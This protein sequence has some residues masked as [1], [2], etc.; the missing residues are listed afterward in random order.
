L[1][2]RSAWRVWGDDDQLGSI[3]LLS[4]ERVQR[5]L[6]LPSRGAVFSLNWSLEEPSPAF[7][8]RASLKHNIHVLLPNVM[9][10]SIDGLFTQASSQ[11]D[12]L[13]H[14][15]HP[16]YGYWN[17]AAESDFTGEEG[18]K[19]GVEQWARKGIVGRGVL[20]DVAR[21]WARTGRTIDGGS[22]VEFTPD[23]LEEVRAAQA[24][25]FEIGDI[26]L[27]RTGWMDWYESCPAEV[28]Q[29]LSEDSINR[30]KTPGLAGGEE[31][32]EWLWNN[33]FAAI[34]ADNPALEAWPHD[35]EVDKY[36]HFRLIPLLGFALGE[37]WYLEELAADCAEDG[38]YEFLVTSAPLNLRGGVGSPPN[39]LAIK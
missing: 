19:N 20:L 2:P 6:G 17:G 32:A 31:T 37:M 4:E 28:K 21:H 1:P 36:L 27:L 34:A 5:A 29:G 35:L 39:V 15:G 10:D 23:D 26:L 9:D 33:H 18:T 14:V 30:L 7:Y 24:T 12:A 38:R 11:W 13:C 16:E 3:N 25:E 22:T 8:G